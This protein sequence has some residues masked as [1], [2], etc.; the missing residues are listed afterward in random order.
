MGEAAW[1]KAVE[2]IDTTTMSIDDLRSHIDDSGMT[3][4]AYEKLLKEILGHDEVTTKESIEALNEALL[5]GKLDAEEYL[6]L[7]KD[8]LTAQEQFDKF[9]QV[10]DPKERQKGFAQISKDDTATDDL[11]LKALEEEGKALQEL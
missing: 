2:G 8:T 1:E 11:R 3:A 4:E 7:T 10:E 9:L 5:K 6:K